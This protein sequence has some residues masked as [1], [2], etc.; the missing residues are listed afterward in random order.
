MKNKLTDLNNHLF[1]QIERL[2]SEDLVSERL[3]EEISRG[4]ALSSLAS[5]VIDNARL[6]LEAAEFSRITHN[7]PASKALSLLVE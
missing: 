2:S 3:S 1:A 6:I 5:N 4:K 7:K